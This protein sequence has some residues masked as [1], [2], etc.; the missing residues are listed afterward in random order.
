MT[1]AGNAQDESGASCSAR[2]EVL[3]E[4]KKHNNQNPQ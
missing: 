3:K 1:E 4:K 2:K